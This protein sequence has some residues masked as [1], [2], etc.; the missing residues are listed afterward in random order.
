MKNFTSAEK[1]IRVV[2]I[3]WVVATVIDVLAQ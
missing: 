2:L 3:L 1:A